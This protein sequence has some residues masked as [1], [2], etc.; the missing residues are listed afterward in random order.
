MVSAEGAAT[1]NS[2]VGL[3]CLGVQCA[4]YRLIV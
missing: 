4:W 1:E 3:M 2:G